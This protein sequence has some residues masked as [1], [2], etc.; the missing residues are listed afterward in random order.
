MERWELKAAIEAV[1]MGVNRPV[2]LA[3]LAEVLECDEQA[4]EEAL[5]EF[6][7]DL[8]AADRGVQVRHRA[9]GVRL[10]VKAQFAD[11]IARAIPEW[12]PK[13]ISSQALETLAIIAMKQPVTIG[14]INAIR[15]VESAGTL[16]TLRNRKLIARVARL[17]PRR[18]KYWRTTPLFLET[19]NLTSVDDL[20]QEGR[21]EEVFPSLAKLEDDCEPE[22]EAGDGQEEVL[23]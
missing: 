6:E 16:Q 11:R 9:Q 5:L 1:L 2:K 14:D 13:P 22:A 20:Y 3:A 21:M 7:S 15:G 10:E 12:A 17:G 8:L 19:F 18:E 23:Q 4:V